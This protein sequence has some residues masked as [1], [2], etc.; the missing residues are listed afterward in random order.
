MNAF[1]PGLDVDALGRSAKCLPGHRSLLE[2]FGLCQYGLRETANKG[3][4]GAAVFSFF[5]LR[6]ERPLFQIQL[7][8]APPL[9]P[10]HPT[11]SSAPFGFDAQ[12]AAKEA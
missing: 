5:H 10:P 11:P 6:S 1:W 2:S 3:V 7:S 4:A 9:G 12:G 8:I